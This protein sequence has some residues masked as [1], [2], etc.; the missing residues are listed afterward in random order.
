MRC[1][2]ASS[3]SLNLPLFI[4]CMKPIS[5]ILRYAI[6]PLGLPEYMVKRVPPSI[7][8]SR[9]VEC[10]EVLGKGRVSLV[11]YC[12]NG[13]QSNTVWS[14]VPASCTHTYTVFSPLR[15]L[16]FSNVWLTAPINKARV[17]G[18]VTYSHNWAGGRGETR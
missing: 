15:T 12:S 9:Y 3:D 5:A 7:G 18:M 8:S 16:S 4:Y 14:E 6:G 1:L 17:A 2:R 13:R 10:M 11:V